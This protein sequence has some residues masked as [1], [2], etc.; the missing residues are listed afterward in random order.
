[1][2]T[3]SKLHIFQQGMTLLHCAAQN[4]HKDV[5]QFA[6]DSPD[7]FDINATDKV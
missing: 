1:M 6:L 4:N 2:L 7:S 5:L 3:F